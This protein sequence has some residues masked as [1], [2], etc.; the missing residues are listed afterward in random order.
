MNLFKII[1]CILEKTG[2]RCSKCGAWN[3]SRKTIK[4]EI[5]WGTDVGGIL[6]TDPYHV[7][8]TTY[9]CSGCGH[10]MKKEERRPY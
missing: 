7:E 9:T 6:L 5:D 1:A 10:S 3:S 8:V 4:E 2:L